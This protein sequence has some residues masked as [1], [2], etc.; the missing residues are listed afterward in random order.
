MNDRPPHTAPPLLSV[1]LLAYRGAA[2]LSDA[3][4]KI[5]A[6]QSELGGANLEIVAVDDGSDDDSYQVILENQNRHPDMIRA[7]RLARNYGSMTAMQ[8]GID[9]ARGDCVTVVPQDLQE[10]PESVVQMYHAWCGGEKIN[11]TC[12]T[13]RDE[14]LLKKIPS[15]SYH[16]LFRILSG[17][18]EYPRGGLGTFLIDRSVADI[19]RAR[20]GRHIDI[21]LSVFTSGPRPRLHPVPRARPKAKSN[22]T[23]AKNFKLV[24]D[25]FIG[26]S[27]LPVRFMSLAGVLTALA[28]FGFAGYVFVG[29]L[30]GWYVIS[31]P[32]GW[33]TIIVLLTLLIGMMMIMLGVIGEYLWRILDEVRARPLY[34]VIEHSP[35]SR[36]ESESN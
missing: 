15:A 36:P 19:L 25:N 29:K 31:Q 28:S 5:A 2:F 34:H 23:L 32:P 11:V 4:E 30:T 13:S 20:P 35:P 3:F 10:T 21:A 18:R 27:Y 16:F 7:V 1:V 22:W 17:M 9:Y 26:F 6:I 24:V 33:A 12:R 14:G 8:A